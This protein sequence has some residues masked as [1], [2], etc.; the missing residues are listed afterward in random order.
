MRRAFYTIAFY[1]I[2]RQY[3]GPE[4]GGWWY[5]S[6]NLERVITT[7]L[8]EDKAYA[9]CRRANHLLDMLQKRRTSIYSVTYNGGRYE[10]QCY[11]GNAPSYYPTIRPHYE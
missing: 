8:N 6:G 2:D 1:E 5:N 9:L 4:E 10:A 7:E 3:G 11:N